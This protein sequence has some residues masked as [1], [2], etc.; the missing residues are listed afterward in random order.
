MQAVGETALPKVWYSLVRA[1]N[2]DGDDFNASEAETEESLR[3]EIPEGLPGSSGHGMH[4]ERALG[5]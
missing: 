1:K 5:T 4:G 2:A 3:G